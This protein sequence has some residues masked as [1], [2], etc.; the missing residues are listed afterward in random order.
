MNTLLTSRLWYGLALLLLGWH[1]NTV[2]QLADAYPK[3]DDLND[4]Y[5]FFGQLHQAHN[6]PEKL[7]AFFF[8]NNEHIT[9]TN[10]LLYW[11]Q[12]QLTNTLDFKALVLCGHLVILL[13]AIVTARLLPAN[14][15]QRGIWLFI[16][17]L[18][19][20]N[21]HS[22]QGSFM[23]MTSL[24]NQSVL[25][26]TVLSLYS[27]QQQHI[28]VAMLCA[29]FASFSQGNGLLA[30]P[31]GL[32]WLV[33]STPRAA[34]RH[35]LCWCV[36]AS[37]TALLYFAMKQHFPLPDQ[38]PSIAA[39]LWTRFHDM[40]W[41]PVTS[42]LV[43]LGSTAWSD[44]H[45]LAAIGTACLCL[46]ACGYVYRHALPQ[47]RIL[48]YLLLFLILS[49]ITASSLRGLAAGTADVM[50]T[51]R[52][53]MYSLLLLLISL[54][55]CNARLP[56]TRQPW[57]TGIALG[58][59]LWSQSSSWRHIPAIQSQSEQFRSSYAA[60][61]VDGDFRRAPV[62]FPPL[63]DYYLFN[64]H[65]LSQHHA[66]GQ[67]RL[68]SLAS[69]PHTVLHPDATIPTS[70]PCPTPDSTRACSLTLT[71]RGN[72]IAMPLQ[73]RTDTALTAPR[74]L[75]CTPDGN[76]SSALTLPPLPR[77]AT[78]HWLLP[79]ASIPPGHYT[80]WLQDSSGTQCSTPLHKKPRK[81]DEQMHALFGAILS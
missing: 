31:V 4:V 70:Q 76:A 61:L 34:W 77:A 72:A 65:Y 41:V 26:F 37:L 23:V 66:L 18:M 49:A 25:L 1:F 29:V 22:W 36:V 20:L 9:A 64:A 15:S 60:W 47:H 48:F 43:F 69:P 56:S 32:L 58:I 53:R 45:T 10:H 40:P 11:L 6:L 3:F 68:L 38:P 8:P 5:G 16:T 71:H 57:M 54:A 2:W 44:S 73:L 21:L 19:Y 46:L 67:Y 33:C 13:T 81:V 28:T 79:E 63:S 52:Y 80:V 42:L 51:S 27:L 24:S 55:L 14:A 35:T 7:A 30:W 12:L 17:L 78:S 50:M 75:L 39:A 74:L 62:Y 59:A